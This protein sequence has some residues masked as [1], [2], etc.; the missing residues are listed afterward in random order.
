MHVVILCITFWEA[1]KH[2]LQSI[3]FDSR[4]STTLVPHFF[5]FGH[6][7]RHMRILVSQLEIKLVPP[8]VEAWSLNLWT[9]R[10]VPVPH[11]YFNC[12]SGFEMISHCGFRF[13]FPNGWWCWTSFQ[14]LIG[15]FYHFSGEMSIQILFPHV[16]GLSFYCLVERDFP[17]CILD[18][19]SLLS[20]ICVCVSHSVMS[21][22]LFATLCTEACQAP[23]SMEFS[24][25]EHWSDLPFPSSGNLSKPGIEPRSPALQAHALPA[26][27]PGKPYL[28]YNLQISSPILWLIISLSW[29]WRTK[30]F[31]ILMKSD[32]CFIWCISK[33]SFANAR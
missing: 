27:P 20:D 15:Y 3:R 14:G 28:I 13:H 21:D 1:D 12:F 7:T 5:S 23:L 31:L 6:I 2:H 33:K 9:A 17:L 32:L 11:F 24:R 16:T 25:Q 22:W 30:V 10:E 19:I 26:E 29:H 18:I 4:S 8:A